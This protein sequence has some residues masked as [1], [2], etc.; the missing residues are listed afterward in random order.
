MEKLKKIFKEKNKTI[1][2]SLIGILLILTSILIAYNSNNTSKLSFSNVALSLPEEKEFVYLSDIP[3]IKEQSSVGW[4]SITLDANLETRYN[5]GLIALIVDGQNKLFLKGISAHATSTLVYDIT[6]LN[7]DYFS[8]Y[9]G[10]DASRGT[11]GNGVKFAI[12]TSVDGIEWTLHTPVSPPIKKG[13]SEAEQ[14]TIDIRGKNYI[15]LYA[16]NNGNADSDHA[17][18]AGAKLYKEGYN[19]EEDNKPY[20]FIKTLE[21]Y[22]NILSN[23]SYDE[24]LTSKEHTLLQR[25]FVSN[26]G[27]DILQGFA[28]LDK[29]HKDVVEWILTDQ[30]AL[31]YYITGGKPTGSYMNSLNV[32]LRLYTAHKED[33]NNTTETAYHTVLGDLYKRMMITLSLTHSTNVCLWVGGAQCS[34]PVRR[35]EIYK[36]MHAGQNEFNGGEILYNQLFESLSIEEMRWVMNNNIDDEEIPWLNYFM[37][38]RGGG[39]PRRGPYQYIRYTFGYNYSLPKY[40]SADE[41]ENWNNKYYLSKYNI[42]YQTGK[43]K[44]WIVFEE[45]SVCGGISKTG[46][47]LDGAVGIP[48]AVLGQPGHAAFIEYSQNTEGKGRWSLNNNISGWAYSEKSERLLCGWG[49]N[50]WDSYYQVSY[51]P[52]AQQALNDLENY[53]KALETMLLAD[54]YSEDLNKLEEIYNK[55]LEYQSYNMDAWYGLIRTYQRNT[56]KTPEDYADLA[57]RLSDEMYHFPLPMYDLMNLITTNLQ[58][59]GYLALRDNYLRLALQKGTA[60]TTENTFVLQYDVSRV[61]ANHLLGNN[62][63]S[64]ASFSFDGENANKLM[65]GTKY[66]GYG[67]RWDYSLDGGHN[68]T[69]TSEHSILLSEAELNS[70]TAENDIKIHIVGSDYS[71]ENIYTIDITENTIS[72][73]N[74]YRNDL[75]NRI[76]GVDTTYEWRR[77]ESDVWTS[78]ATTSPNNTGN[79][80]LQIRQAATGTKLAS[81][82]LSFEFTEDN[83]PL[84]RKYVPVSHLAIDSFSTES[85]DTARPY[86]APNAI[87][88]NAN[89]LWHTDFRE[90]VLTSGNTPF[91]TIKLDKPRYISAI[92]LKQLKYRSNDPIYVKNFRIYIS[93]DNEN[94]TLAGSMENCPVDEELRVIDFSESVYGEYI[95]IEMDTYNIFASLSLVNVFQ[96]MTK[97]PRPTAG[98]AYSPA[99]PTNGNVIARLDNISTEHYEI[100]SPGGNTHVF[101]DN[102]EFTFR[103]RD[104]DTNVEGSAKAKVT[105]ID[106]TI[107]TA[108]IEYSTNNPT[109]KEV[110]ATLKPSEDVTV[111]NNTNYRLNEDDKVVDN[112]GNVLEG[113]TIVDG[114]VIDKEGNKIASANPLT[115]EFTDN[116]EFTFEFV[117]RAGNKGSATAKVDWID[118]TPPIATLTYDNSLL[119]NKDVTVTISFNEEA[120]VTNNSNSKTYTFKENG[121]F[122]FEYRDRAGNTGTITARVNWIDKVA[123]TAELKYENV[124]NKVVVTVI[125]PS[126]EI[127]YAEGIGVYE[128]T[129][130]GSYEIVFYDKA[131]NEGKLIAEIKSFA[132]NPNEPD[133]PNIPDNPSEPDKPENPGENEKPG[134]TEPEKPN[135]S[136]NNKPN[137]GNNS[138]SHNKPGTNKPNENKP[139]NTEY[140][141]FNNK[142]IIVEIP[143]SSLKEEGT[144][145]IE[146]FEL[147]EELIGKFGDVSE[148]YDIYYANNNS[149]RV[150]VSSSSPIKISI[151]LKGL[152]EFIGVYEITD[153][154]IIKPVDYVKNGN[155]IEIT[156]KSLGKYV[157]SYKEIKIVSPSIT[158]PVGSE[159][160]N[161]NKN[162]IWIIGSIG[163]IILGFA[164]YFFKNPKKDKNENNFS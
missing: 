148:Y 124:D 59:T 120:T 104:T 145:K 67:V 18:Y 161:K 101:T 61:M 97:N 65:L 90:N 68:W 153:N 116:G 37:R 13:N 9:Y 144:I 158:V 109:N 154:N 10:V 25:K 98:I 27:Y 20:D 29:D 143:T 76:M 129:K 141:K 45:G 142:G 136:G 150:K 43:P 21:E 131:G 162:L 135:N 19:N 99:E 134:P 117:D 48:S 88:G 6:G 11:N 147:S 12:Y 72:E 57:K 164:I 39:E 33:L 107:P 85:I 84:T 38:V 151:R 93:E 28:H 157:V 81:N 91:I 122:T 66:E 2:L 119:T 52:Y 155:N 82:V 3:Y 125:N 128:F 56:A 112:E 121:S 71:P 70:I 92:E 152:K 42:T 110:I 133:N 31:K 62:D 46:S 94:W 118:V 22:D 35:Y 137:G 49:S 83:Q 8:T 111:T 132:D 34:D 89:T 127:T 74:F 87:D 63:Y 146:E 47:N 5:N 159:K 41:Y 53:N 14:V 1:T 44:L 123:P 77:N 73:S 95:K 36:E 78:Y 32:L 16:H 55:A 103:F 69:A 108:T 23:A 160:N 113:F 106:R 163:A 140:Q 4:G 17:T 50:T 105:W 138:G 7:Y 96:D 26:I 30:Q 24:L 79:K 64:I 156:S 60:L 114:Y 54:S 40:Y 102:G 80:T 51:I 126:E 100:L 15:K 115:Y 149:N 86:Y 75:E 58:G 130:N 139:I